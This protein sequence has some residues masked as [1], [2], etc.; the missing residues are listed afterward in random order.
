MHLRS[1]SADD[2]YLELAAAAA[3]HDLP[4]SCSTHAALDWATQQQQHRQAFQWLPGAPQHLLA[5]VASTCCWA[6]ACMVLQLIN[7]SAV[8]W[9]AA[10]GVYTRTHHPPSAPT[11]AAAGIRSG[12]CAGLRCSPG[13]AASVYAN[14]LVLFGSQ[15]HPGRLL[16]A[17]DD[18][19]C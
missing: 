9:L 16:G 3:C 4:G 15:H 19:A 13:F 10:G 7:S 17:A 6:A 5:A 12:W 8:Q 11:T 2:M 18:A 14:E 1:R